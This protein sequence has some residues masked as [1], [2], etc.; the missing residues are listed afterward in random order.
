MTSSN[1]SIIRVTGPI[2]TSG[3][4]K[5]IRCPS[6]AMMTSSNGNIIRVTGPICG[7]SPITGKKSP[8][9]GQWRRALMFSLICAWINAWVNNREAGDLRRHRAHYDVI[10]MGMG[11]GMSMMSICYRFITEPWGSSPW[12]MIRMP[13][14]LNCHL[15]N[16]ELVMHNSHGVMASQNATVLSSIPI[17]KI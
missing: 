7:E 1:G 14:P 2:C 9:K 15:N 10:V 11:H 6:L 16:F 3:L 13:V 4:Q 5:G 8:H 17:K 12:G